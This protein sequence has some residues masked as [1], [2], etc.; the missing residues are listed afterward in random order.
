MRM[1]GIYEDADEDADGWH[2][3][4][5]RQRHGRGTKSRQDD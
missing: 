3:V 1:E 2:G 5:T 4:E